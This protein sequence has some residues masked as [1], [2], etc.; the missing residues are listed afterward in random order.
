MCS[1]W[2]RV[3][4][5]VREFLDFSKNAL[6]CFLSKGRRENQAFESTM[7]EVDKSISYMVG[8][9]HNVLEGTSQV[10]TH[11]CITKFS[12]PYDHSKGRGT[13]PKYSFLAKFKIGGEQGANKRNW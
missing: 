11:S 1:L 4:K 10:I 9:G 13:D 2:A 3:V 5:E 12:E 8:N 6:N 7:N